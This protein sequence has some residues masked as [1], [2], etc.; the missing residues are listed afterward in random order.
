MGGSPGR[1]VSPAASAALGAFASLF[2]GINIYRFI[3][4]LP[5]TLGCL[6]LGKNRAGSSLPLFSSLSR[7]RDIEDQVR[8]LLLRP[9]GGYV[10]SQT[11]LACLAVELGGVMIRGP[12]LSFER[13]L[14]LHT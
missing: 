13:N 6:P 2:L 9:V 11:L 3:C 5:Y 8:L 7:A 4:C 1:G 10:V 14:I 12:K